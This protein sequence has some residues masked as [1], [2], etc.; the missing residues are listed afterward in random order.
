MSA[1]KG[2]FGS[3]KFWL[4]VIGSVVVGVMKYFGLPEDVIMTI[5]GLFGLNI[6]GQGLAD[7][8]K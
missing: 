6:L 3:K 8:K 2:L 4:V 7:T 1:L 5:A